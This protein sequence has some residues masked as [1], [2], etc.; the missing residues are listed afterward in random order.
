MKAYELLFFISPSID[1]EV[2]LA[3]MKRIDDTIITQGGVVDNVDEWGKR[4]LA[5]E[6][7]GLTEGNYTLIDFHTEPA[8]IAELDRVLHISDDVVRYMIV[9]RDDRS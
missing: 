7:D 3:M 6:V 4:K 2:R 9:R 5:F 8:A 1:D